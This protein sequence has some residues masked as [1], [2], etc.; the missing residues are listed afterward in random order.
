MSSLENATLVY[1]EWRDSCSMNGTWSRMHEVEDMEPCTIRSIGWLV[2]ETN[3]HVVVAA[4]I[5]NN[6]S[7]SGD[8][9]VPKAVITH[10]MKLPQP[11]TTKSK[12]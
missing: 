11:R 10:R 2:S 7:L 6:D 9:C 8:L 5:S 3:E 12:R 1:I 4:H